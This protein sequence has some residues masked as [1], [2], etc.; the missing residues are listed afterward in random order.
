VNDSWAQ[1]IGKLSLEH[2][3]GGALGDGGYQLLGLIC[4]V[5]MGVTLLRVALQ[6]P[7]PS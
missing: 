4:F 3:L 2:A 1:A 7:R 5:I 6:K